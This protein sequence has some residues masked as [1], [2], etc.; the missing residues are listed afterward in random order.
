M[1][2]V[3]EFLEVYVVKKKKKNEIFRIIHCKHFYAF[4][5]VFVSNDF[6]QNFSKLLSFVLRLSELRG[7]HEELVI[8]ALVTE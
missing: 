2:S 7:N 1:D 4:S 8:P 3:S 5:L 6:K